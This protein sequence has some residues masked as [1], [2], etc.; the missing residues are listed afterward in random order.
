MLAASGIDY[1]IKIITP[2]AEKDGFDP[3]V[4]E[5]LVNKN[6]ILLEESRDTI[7]LPALFMLRMLRHSL[8]SEGRNNSLRRLIHR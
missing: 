7:T 2:T 5:E 8:S 1:S 6:A 3:V 4:A